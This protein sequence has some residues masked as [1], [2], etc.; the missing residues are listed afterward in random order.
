MALITCH[1]CGAQISD[2]AVACPHCG[3][4]VAQSTTSAPQPTTPE[5]Q[6]TTPPAC[7]E[8]H[9]AK[10]IVLT[11]LCCWPL[12]IPAIVNAAEVNTEYIAG[13]YES[14]LQKSKNAEK[15]CK[16]CIIAGVVF[17]ALYIIAMVC[18]ALI[19]EFA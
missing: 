6:P 4:P 15:W 13:R 12:G 11:I 19:E 9:L 16:Y 14:A 17:W 18:F 5:P 8:T 2:A 1:E 3:A 7:P 10:A